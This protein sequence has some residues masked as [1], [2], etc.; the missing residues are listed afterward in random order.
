[1]QNWWKVKI[2]DEVDL[3]ANKIVDNHEVNFVQEE[4]IESVQMDKGESSMYIFDE[5]EE[6]DIS[7]DNVVQTR[8]Q[9]INLKQKKMWKK[10]RKI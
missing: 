8:E 5:H 10:K 9:K 3:C 2:F 4:I 7:L 1:M 6:I